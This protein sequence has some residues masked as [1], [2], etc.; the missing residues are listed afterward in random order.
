M[1]VICAAIKNREV[2]ISC[3]TQFSFG[4]LKIS[5]KHKRDANKLFTVKSSVI[6]LTGWTAIANMMEHLTIHDK[7]LFQLHDRM[8]IYGTM[9]ALHGKMK[10]DYFIETNEDD[11]Q[12]VES[13]QLR[14][15][16][17]NEH[18]IF[19][20]CSYREVNEFKSYWAIGS[21]RRLAL[22]ALHALYEQKLSAKALVE[23]GVKAAAEFDDGCGL[24][25]K[26][27]VLKMRR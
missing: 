24:P 10:S 6:G 14:V 7:D 11:D 15:L 19:E 27:K 5:S 13:S 23:A 26:T 2:A 20:V 1:S 16:I 12:P 25:L 9:L 3:D 17:V 21:G 18:G 4:S 22:G 8:S